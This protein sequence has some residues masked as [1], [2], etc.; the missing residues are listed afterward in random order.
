M[1]KRG[2]SEGVVLADVGGT[3]ARFAILQDGV[4]GGIEHLKV[5]AYPHFA[6]ALDAFMAKRGDH[7][8][9]RHALFGV[10]GVVERERC[11]LTNNP[12]IVSANELRDRFGFS[13]IDIVNDFEAV[14]WS[15]PHLVG[16]DLHKIGGR[17]PDPAAPKVVLGPGTGLGV[18]AYLPTKQ[19][20]LVVRSEGGHATLPSGSAGEDAIIAKL[21][22]Q[23]GHV[24]AERILSGNGLE[25]LY[26]AI[27]SLELQTLPELSAAEIM[28]AA[29]TGNCEF[30]R[31][32]VDTFCALLGSVAGN[33]A[34]SFGAQGGVYIAG[35]IAPH[36]RDHLP[37]SQFRSRF[38]AKGR[39]TTYLESI[40]TYLILHDDPAF[41]GLQWLALQ[42]V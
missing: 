11:V 26:H 27:A 35:G 41:V 29:C 37:V 34:L 3:N 7:R 16:K 31:T 38:E 33:L 20:D 19:G 6:D 14:A 12:W 5:A 9:I 25:N 4:L 40:P 1:A 32:A 21:R 22:Q 10:A 18:A 13:T 8:P 39:L 23:F 15:L 24:S 36:L 17:E 2:K 30:S 42:Q 28:Q